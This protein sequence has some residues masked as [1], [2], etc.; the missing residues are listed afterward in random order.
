MSR[1][2]AI[3]A[4]KR[5]GGDGQAALRAELGCFRL[6]GPLLQELAREYAFAR[7]AVINR[8]NPKNAKETQGE[9]EE[10]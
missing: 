2:E 7:C 10:M 4:L 1:E 3:A 6:D 8:A 5:S 9:K